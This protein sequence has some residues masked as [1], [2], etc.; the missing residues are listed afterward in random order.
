[1]PRSAQQRAHQRIQIQS[2]HTLD[3]MHVRAG[4]LTLHAR[5]THPSAL[6]RATPRPTDGDGDGP[7]GHGRTHVECRAHCASSKGRQRHVAR[8]E[9]VG[10]GGTTGGGVALRPPFTPRRSP[11]R[12]RNE[13]PRLGKSNS[14]PRTYGLVRSRGT[15]LECCPRRGHWRGGV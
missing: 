14:F 1:M 7:R 3:F 4:G 2:L 10:R 15:F 6:A 9:P 11:Q 12:A 13:V 8:V 5:R